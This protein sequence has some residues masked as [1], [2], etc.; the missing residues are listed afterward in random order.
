MKEKIDLFTDFGI[1][2]NLAEN[3]IKISQIEDYQK[4]DFDIYANIKYHD[5]S[6]L[7]NELQNEIGMINKYQLDATKKVL[8]DWRENSKNDAIN[9]SYDI[10]DYISDISKK[11]D[12]I[13]TIILFFNLLML[14]LMKS[15]NPDDP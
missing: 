8:D 13:F 10:F 6:V 14:K 1:S 12:K 4:S 5:V 3:L 9:Q 2:K 15:N 11:L 7:F